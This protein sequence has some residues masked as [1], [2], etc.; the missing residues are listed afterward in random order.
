MVYVVYKNRT[1][2]QVKIEDYASPPKAEEAIADNWE[3][4]SVVDIFMGARA[5]YNVS[6]VDVTEIVERKEPKIDIKE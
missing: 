3:K 2:S 1:G 4:Y 6:Y 5:K